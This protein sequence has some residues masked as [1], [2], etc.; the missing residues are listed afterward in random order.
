MHVGTASL[1]AAAVIWATPAIFM[2]WLGRTFDPFSM[3][4][5][6]YAVA[7]AAL[8]VFLAC[9]RER[10]R[11][12][13]AR[14][15][16]ALGIVLVPSVVYQTAWAYAMA[17]HL[18]YPATGSLIMQLSLIVSIV[19]GYFIFRDERAVIRAPRF[20][21]GTALA[22]AGVAGVILTASGGGETPTTALG[23]GLALTAAVGWGFYNVAIKRAVRATGPHMAFTV[24]SVYMTVSLLVIAILFGDLAAPFGAPWVENVGLVGSGVA[25]IA[26]AHLLYYVGIRALGVAVG[27]M[28]ILTI[29]VLTAV[30]SGLILGDRL[31]VL[32]IAFGVALLVGTYLALDAGLKTIAA[33]PDLSAPD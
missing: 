18:I 24:V 11:L 9:R 27:S 8:V 3:N 25:C 13:A 6:R 17:E 31:T 23:A 32:Q 30:L 20:L 16:L 15:M 14:E 26:V 10:P 21:A 28:S 22:L 4:F 1:A 29:P 5:Y 2:S 12:P 33:A 19:A 7:A